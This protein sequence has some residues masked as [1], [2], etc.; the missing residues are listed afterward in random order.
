[1]ITL[2]SIQGRRVKGKIENE[3]HHLKI[4][5]DK[6]ELQFIRRVNMLAAMTVDEYTTN[7]LIAKFKVSKRRIKEDIYYLRGRLLVTSRKDSNG[8]RLHHRALP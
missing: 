4:V 1:M 6:R 7:A 8:A 3:W 5:R 2:D